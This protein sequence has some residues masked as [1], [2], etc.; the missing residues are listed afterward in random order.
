MRNT[1]QDLKNGSESQHAL[2]LDENLD[3]N[4]YDHVN[5]AEIRF[6][7]YCT[8]TRYGV[9]LSSGGDISSWWCWEIR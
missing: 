7:T 8:I 9:A 2:Y 1:E 3:E 5:F 4:A 6:E